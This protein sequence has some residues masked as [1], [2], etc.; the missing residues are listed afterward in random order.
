MGKDLGGDQ[1]HEYF[2]VAVYLR[3]L[4]LFL[5]NMMSLKYIFANA[6]LVFQE[7]G[8]MKTTL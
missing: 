1:S 5:H 7:F 6:N 3:T 2:S 4:R 8:Q